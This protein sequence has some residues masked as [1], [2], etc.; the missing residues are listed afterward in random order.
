MMATVLPNDAYT[1]MIPAISG[2]SIYMDGWE[3][4][5]AADWT[6]NGMN[7]PVLTDWIGLDNQLKTRSGTSAEVVIEW[8]GEDGAMIR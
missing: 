4:T 1:P 3:T 5:L 8:I 2:R 6:P 7:S